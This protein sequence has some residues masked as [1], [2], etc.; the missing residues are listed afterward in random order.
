MIKR[1]ALIGTLLASFQIAPPLTA[2]PTVTETASSSSTVAS[3]IIQ[4]GDTLE[5]LFEKA[6]LSPILRSEMLLA[7]AAEFDAREL[8]PGNRLIL[9]WRDDARTSLAG[10]ELQVDGGVRVVIDLARSAEALTIEP[11][12]LRLE[13]KTSAKIAGSLFGTLG[14]VEAPQRLAVELPELLAGLVDFR[15]DLKGGEGLNLTWEEVV[16]AETGE[17]FDVFLRYAQVTLTNRHYEILLDDD[18]DELAVVLQDGQP[19][20][21]IEPPVS[22]A[23]LSSAFGRRMHP[24]LGALRLHT[25]VDYAAS[26]GDLVFATSPGT[27]NFVG[28]VPGYGQIIDID[29]GDGVVSRYAHLSEVAGGMNAGDPIEAGDEI[30][31]VG[32]TGLATGPNLHYEIRVDGKPV[33]PLDPNNAIE[34]AELTLSSQEREVL[35][36][37]RAAFTTD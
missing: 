15:R 31:R 1:I 6:G 8:R 11:E 17:V 27:V 9:R 23:R 24:V 36:D 12:I 19:V 3:Y 25:G 34:P 28:Q 20:R 13:K 26:K 10:V 35:A 4:P 7:V 16:D 18:A 5:R 37:L 32:R 14:A 29:H 22:G 33:D 30:G 2:G 21:R